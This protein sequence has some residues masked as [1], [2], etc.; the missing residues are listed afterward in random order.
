MKRTNMSLEP[1]LV[2]HLP[3]QLL[4]DATVLITEDEPHPL[5]SRST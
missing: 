5:E 2:A 4:D 3:P 1:V